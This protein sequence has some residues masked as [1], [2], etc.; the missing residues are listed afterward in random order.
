M[1]GRMQNRWLPLEVFESPGLLLIPSQRINDNNKTTPVDC[2]DGRALF[3]KESKLPDWPPKLQQEE[4][5]PAT[6]PWATITPRLARLARTFGCESWAHLRRQASQ[7]ATTKPP[8]DYDYKPPLFSIWHDR[9]RTKIYT[10]RMFDK[11]A[12]DFNLYSRMKTTDRWGPSIDSWQTNK[13]HGRPCCMETVGFCCI[14]LVSD[15]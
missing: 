6:E 9:C 1:A 11:A 3:F 7:Y 13:L 10:S 15:N 8:T 12:R 4:M 5:T 2:Q 14:N